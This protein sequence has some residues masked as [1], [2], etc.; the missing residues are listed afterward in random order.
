MSGSSSGISSKCKKGQ[1]LDIIAGVLQKSIKVCYLI[2]LT[3]YGYWV[4][5]DTYLIKNN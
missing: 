5:F 4:G 1:G 3:E 2:D